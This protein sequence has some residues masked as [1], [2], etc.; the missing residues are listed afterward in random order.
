MARDS[1]AEVGRDGAFARSPSTFLHAL[2]SPAF[3]LERDRYVLY[4][5]R[6]CP[7]ACRVLAVIAHRGLEGLLRVVVCAPT[8][9]RTKPEADEHRG[10]VFRAR[11]APGGVDAGLAEV[12]LAE[13]VFGAETVRGVYELLCAEA[14]VP[15]PAKFT[16]PLLVDARARRIVCNESSILLRDLGGPLADAFATR[17]A[18]VPLRPAAL[19]AAVD[20]EC[21]AMYEALNNGVY[22]CGFA[23][24]QAAY[25]AAAAALAAWLDAA[26][27]RLADGRSFLCGAA[28]TEADV[29][30]YVTLVRYDAVYVV[31]FKCVFRTVRGL[32]RLAAY[33][34]RVHAALRGGAAAGAAHPVT[35]LLHIKQHYFASHPTLNPHAIVPMA[36]PGEGAEFDA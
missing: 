12:P 3:P 21:E 20:A 30:A 16:V 9:A 28:L 19:L 36:A 22:R 6:A 34:R 5:S 8:W 26:E 10:W 17:G 18:S 32:P 1:L 33:V 15:P 27:A 29:R 2:G 13:P 7:W 25:D 4:V 35:D 31:H 23:T 24:T 14:G 11:A